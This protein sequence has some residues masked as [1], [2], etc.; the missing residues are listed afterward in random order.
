LLLLPA[1]APAHGLEVTV[2]PLPG[3]RLHVEAGYDDG[4][5]AEGAT[6]TVS[7]ALGERGRATL[8]ARGVG[9]LPE[10]A[11]R[12]RVVVDDGVGHR[13][14]VDGYAERPA[15]PRWP[16]AV[17]GVGLIAGWA[18]WRAARRRAAVFPAAGHPGGEPSP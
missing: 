16:F 18:G 3:G 10:P 6:A 1:L 11:G 5:P 12:W 14:A 7:D 4:T 8:D 17:A 2:R 15:L 9:E 13:T